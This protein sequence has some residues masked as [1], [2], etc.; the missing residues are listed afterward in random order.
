M[1]QNMKIKDLRHM[2]KINRKFIQGTNWALAGLLSLLGFAGCEIIGEDEY[3]CPHA[4]YEFSGKVTNEK[5]EP[6][7]DIEI[8]VNEASYNM[9]NHKKR[10]DTNG[11]YK[12][13]VS[14]MTGNTYHLI[15]TDKDGVEN[16]FY[17][18][19]TIAVTFTKEDFY[20]KG[21]GWYEGAARKEINI[22]LKE[23]KTSVD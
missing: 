19:D 10:T 11:M 23:E 3:G 1:K 21:K 8:S 20:K 13:E 18:N 12:I 9:S 15:A 4:D 22:T 16:G 6:L 7:P 17:T 2:K 5:G 14:D